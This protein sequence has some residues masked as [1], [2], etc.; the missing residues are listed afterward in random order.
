MKF[1]VKER[2]NKFVLGIYWA[3]GSFFGGVRRDIL[4]K[5]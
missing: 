4:Q 5:S 1:F 3:M 2:E